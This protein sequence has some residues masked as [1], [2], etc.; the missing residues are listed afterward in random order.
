MPSRLMFDPNSTVDSP[1]VEEQ[2]CSF[3]LELVKESE[4]AKCLFWDKEF[5]LLVVSKP[6]MFPLICDG[7]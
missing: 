7:M 3:S 6:V 5:P 4:W 1:L 2:F